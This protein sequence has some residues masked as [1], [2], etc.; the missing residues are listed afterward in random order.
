[1]GKMRQDLP[2]I[3]D[4]EPQDDITGYLTKWKRQREL[5][6]RLTC[7]FKCDGSCDNPMSKLVVRED[8]LCYN[9]YNSCQTYQKLTREKK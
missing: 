4:F 8:I 9:N 1:M 3:V 2:I 5:G 7:P 6:L